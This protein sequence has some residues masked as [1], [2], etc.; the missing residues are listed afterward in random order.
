[1]NIKIFNKSFPGKRKTRGFT[2]V[3]VV[4]AISILTMILG[5]AYSAITQII[6]TKKILDDKRDTSLIA[7][8]IVRRL[9]KELQLTVAEHNLI[10]SNPAAAPSAN[11]KFLGTARTNLG[12]G[13]SLTF[14]AMEGGQYLP[15]GGTH[16]GL[17]Q[18]TYR[19]AKD[20]EKREVSDVYSLIREE[21]P[22][23]SLPN[24]SDPRIWQTA[25]E[26]AFSKRIIFP[27]AENVLNFKL[28]F[29]D[30]YEDRWSDEWGAGQKDIPA[31]INYSV[32]L[33]SELGNLETY[34]TTVPLGPG[35]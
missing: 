13:S 7:S 10:F 29:Y 15:D 33:I 14:I 19:L 12:E 6:S 4:I 1:M 35:R 22:Y 5:T 34:E 30:L 20:P 27:I 9:S 28:K 17:V 3:E 16:T 25:V 23:V 26:K 21:M 24:T 11:L 18:I 2:L 32:T 31:M 8:S